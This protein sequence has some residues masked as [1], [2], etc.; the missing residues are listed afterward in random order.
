MEDNNEKT[1]T[2]ASAPD[3]PNASTIQITTNN[4]DKPVEHLSVTA[5]TSILPAAEEE[6]EELLFSDSWE[7][8]ENKET[9][10]S[11]SEG[12]VGLHCN[13][14]KVPPLQKSVAQPAGNPIAQPGGN[15][16]D[17]KENDGKANVADPHGGRSVVEDDEG[18]DGKE[19]ATS[20]EGMNIFIYH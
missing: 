19:N 15:S 9:L 3:E 11:D 8:H 5:A 12:D 2:L 16:N 1:K 14:K 4:R 20:S 7:S 17:G 10:S 13:G 18:S 6:Q